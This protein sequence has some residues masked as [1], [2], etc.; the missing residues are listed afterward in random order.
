MCECWKSVPTNLQIINNQ[1]HW[2]SCEKC[3]SVWMCEYW[4]SVPTNLQIWQNPPSK[5]LPGKPQPFPLRVVIQYWSYTFCMVNAY[6]RSQSCLPNMGPKAH[7]PPLGGLLFIWNPLNLNTFE[8]LGFN[9]VLN[10]IC[11]LSSKKQNIAISEGISREN[12]NYPSRN[13]AIAE[14]IVRLEM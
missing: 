11:I 1:H 13:V 4:K 9:E 6:V 12:F 7:P 14:E 2:V 10:L 8:Y 5:P 3:V